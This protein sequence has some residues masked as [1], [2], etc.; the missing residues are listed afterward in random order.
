[1][2]DPQPSVAVAVPVAL[3][4]VGVPHSM[5]RFAGAVMLG[6]VVSRTVIVCIALE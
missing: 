5:V 4:V 6:G 1:M 3:V 2:T